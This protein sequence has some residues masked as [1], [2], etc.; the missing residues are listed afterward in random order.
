MS[1]DDRSDIIPYDDLYRMVTAYELQLAGMQNQ[2]M[3]AQDYDGVLRRWIPPRPFSDLTKPER[4]VA[5]TRVIH[6]S[7]EDI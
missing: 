5:V 4:D 6:R 3:F 2:V 1:L 7:R